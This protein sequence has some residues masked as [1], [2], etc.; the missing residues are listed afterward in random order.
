[1]N[2]F[3]IPTK[4]VEL[5]SATMEGTKACVKIQNHLADYFEVKR[6]LKQGDRAGTYPV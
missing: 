4:L 1:M 2:C 5:V 6:G 3:G